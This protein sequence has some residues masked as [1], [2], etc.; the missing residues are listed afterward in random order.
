MA[1]AVINTRKD[2]D[3]IAGTPQHAAFMAMLAG[4]LWR[5][6]RDDDARRWLA[7]E[8]DSTIVR[9]GLSRADFPKA[10]PPA[11]PEYIPSPGLAPAVAEQK[12]REAAIALDALPA[13]LDHI[14][15]G[16]DAP[17]RIKDAA[18]EM[19]ALKSRAA[20]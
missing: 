7:V 10:L 6:V 9:Y 13:L 17:R 1:S 16:A 3:A 20:A 4:T 19:A 15:S 18:A 2:L 8:D 11:L 5:M 14:A 12:A